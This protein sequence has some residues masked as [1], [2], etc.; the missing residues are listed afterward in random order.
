LARAH[1]KYMKT[2][3]G[4]RRGIPEAAPVFKSLPGPFNFSGHGKG[5]RF[6]RREKL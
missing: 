5:K 4:S 2:D 1:Q 6:T 3:R